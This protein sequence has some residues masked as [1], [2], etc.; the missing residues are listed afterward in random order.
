MRM[1][2]IDQHGDLGTGVI[3]FGLGV[4]VVTEKGS[5]V[6]PW[7]A[8]SY[9]WGGMFATTYWVDPKEKLVALIYRNVYPTSLGTI[10]DQFRVMSYAAI[11]D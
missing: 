10:V 7:N 8:G 9:E 2:T 1:M 5:G 3:D 6:Q 4:G 11:N